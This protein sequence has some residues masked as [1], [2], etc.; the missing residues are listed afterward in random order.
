MELKR[1]KLKKTKLIIKFIE[2][3][4]RH[5]LVIFNK[6]KLVINENNF[7]IILFQKKNK[8]NV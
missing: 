4:T 3:L 7:N 5:T 1:I 6:Y 8:E 2:F